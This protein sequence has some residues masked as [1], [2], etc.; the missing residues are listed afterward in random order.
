MVPGELGERKR[1]PGESGERRRVQSL[2]FTGFWVS[3]LP[4]SITGF[5][6][7]FRFL[8]SVTS[9][10]LPQLVSSEAIRVFFFQENDGR[11]LGSSCGFKGSMLL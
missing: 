11:L 9:R 3:V 7:G 6:L 10:V 8:S 5:F 1:V 2:F 4:L